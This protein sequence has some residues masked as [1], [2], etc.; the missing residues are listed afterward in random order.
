MIIKR[1]VYHLAKLTHGMLSVVGAD[2]L[3][4]LDRGYRHS[5][6]KVEAVVSFREGGLPGSEEEHAAVATLVDVRQLKTLVE[7]EGSGM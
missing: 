2:E 5:P 3:E 6:P 1:V 7:S 4:V